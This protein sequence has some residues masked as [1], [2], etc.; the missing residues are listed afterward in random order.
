MSARS[1]SRRALIVDE[2]FMIREQFRWALPPLRWLASEAPDGESAAERALR[3]LPDVI[4]TTNRL[5]GLSGTQLCR[6]LTADPRTRSVDV[7]V[8]G[9]ANERAQKFWARESGAGVRFIDGLAA[10]RG[11]HR[12]ALPPRA[13]P[14][15]A[16]ASLP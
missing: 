6:L 1:N 16:R 3:E 14:R 9:G 15:A 10:T 12:G 7:I 13:P 4:I 2:S 5:R 8:V 11:H